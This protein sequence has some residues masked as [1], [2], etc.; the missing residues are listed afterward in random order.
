MSGR[1]EI[2]QPLP[3]NLEAERAVI[4]AILL[5]NTVTPNIQEVFACLEHVSFFLP[6]HRIIYSRLKHMHEHGKPT[7]DLVVLHE[8]LIEANELNAAG[9]AEYVSS[10]ANGLPRVTNIM[11]YV[12][13]VEIK[14]RLRERV[15]LAETI[16]QKLL[17]ANGNAFDVLREVSTLSAPLREE[18]GQKRIFSFKSG[19]EFGAS[20]EDQIVWI[21]P[22]YVAK[23]AITEL[24]ARVKMGKTTL[25]LNLVR[26]AADG[27]N[28]LGKPTLKTST[29]YL[30]EQ[31]SAS[32][33]QAMERAGLLGRDDFQLLLHNQIRMAPWPEIVSAA[34]AECKRVAASLLVVD[35]LPQFA[36]LIGDTENNSGDALAAMLPL[37]HAAAEGLAVIIVRHERKSGGDVGDS[38][39]GSSAFAGAADIVL[40]LRKKEGNSKKTMRLLQ[41]VSRFSETP[42]EQIIELR[43]TTYFSLGEPREAALSEVKTSIISAAFKSESTAV[44]LEGFSESFRIPRVT[45]QRAIKELLKEGK[46]A[47]VGQGKKGKPYRYF[48][49]EIPF[50]PTPDIGGQED[51]QPGSAGHRN[52]KPSQD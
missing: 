41:A 9:G 25:I 24:G 7:N 6:Q 21:V 14:A 4:G 35:T 45:A 3:C 49:P 42:A 48:T 32:F 1:T 13:I 20:T 28:F 23:G 37:Q 8:A 50:C 47:R 39:R 16:L 46:L 22:G 51:E 43:E 15:Y 10:I 31:P 12:Q 33:R 52:G 18:V 26:A 34:V 5:A 29:V 17:S 2:E 38:G 19:R 44:G 27:H 36:R 11:H 30:T 40:S